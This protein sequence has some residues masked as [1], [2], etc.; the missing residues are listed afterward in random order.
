MTGYLK[1]RSTNHFLNRYQ[2][3]YHGEA[4]CGIPIEVLFFSN[5]IEVKDR[6]KF[7]EGFLTRPEPVDLTQGS[8]ARISKNSNSAKLQSQPMVKRDC[9]N[10]VIFIGHIFH[11]P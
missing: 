10:E 6:K 3:R 5:P 9:S 8:N 4:S 1:K 2:N 7:K 11:T